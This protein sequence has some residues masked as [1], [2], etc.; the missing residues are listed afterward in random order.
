MRPVAGQEKLSMR[1]SR[2][3]SMGMDGIMG[4]SVELGVLGRGREALV[5]SLLRDT[6]ASRLFYRIVWVCLALAWGC[7]ALWNCRFGCGD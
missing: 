2:W 4:L 6:G 1:S 5:S 3:C 7:G